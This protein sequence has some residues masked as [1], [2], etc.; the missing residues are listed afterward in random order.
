MFVGKA[1]RVLSDESGREIDS[2]SDFQGKRGGGNGG[3]GKGKGRRE[4]PAELD[5]SS[6]ASELSVLLG[7]NGANGASLAPASSSSSPYALGGNLGS[8]ADSLAEFRPVLAESAVAKIRVSASKELWS[9]V[10]DSA[11]LP[12]HLRAL[13]DY[14]LLARGDTYSVFVQAIA[15]GM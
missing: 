12:G 10:V 6:I 15:K 14:C 2:D 4:L 1:V 9:L 8:S 3:R 5:R 13:R 11:D 7:G